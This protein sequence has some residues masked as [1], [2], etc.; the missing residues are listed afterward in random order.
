LEL[1]PEE[2]SGDFE[3]SFEVDEDTAN[4]NDIDFAVDIESDTA[5]D[6]AQGETSQ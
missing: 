6:A 5:S 3:M 1:V 2:A 4:R